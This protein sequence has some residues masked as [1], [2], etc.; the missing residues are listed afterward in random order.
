MTLV[1]DA[2]FVVAWLVDDGIDGSWAGSVIGSGDL[3]APHLMPT[4]VTQVLRNE[5][6]AGRLSVEVASLAHHDLLRMDVALFAYVSL[7]PRVW[8]LRANVSAY[9]ACYVAL[10]E[11]QNAP[12][13][14]LDRRLA[15]ATGP[16][17]EFLTP[18]RALLSG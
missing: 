9:D 2:S 18:P 10:A 6:L 8:E 13:A 14:T 4:E 1:V 15:R 11:M 16:R 12:L 7:A 3:A 17:C 5:S